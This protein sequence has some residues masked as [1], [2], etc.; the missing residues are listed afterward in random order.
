MEWSREG[1]RVG[2]VW[3]R[4]G[5]PG[6]GRAGAGEEGASQEGGTL[7]FL[8]FQLLCAAEDPT[9]SCSVRAPGAPKASAVGMVGPRRPW[10]W[11]EERRWVE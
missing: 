4:R 10:T 2:L 3:G 1:R 8:S 6:R 9:C 5:E 11:A 7:S